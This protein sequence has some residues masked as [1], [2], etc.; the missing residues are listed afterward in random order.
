MSVYGQGLDVAIVAGAD[1]SAQQ[2]KP[3]NQGGTLAGSADNLFGILQG[4]PQAAEHATVRVTG[5][6]KLYMSCSLGAGADIMVS[7]ATSGVIALATSGYCSFGKVFI[8]AASGSIG[9]AFLFGGPV[10]R[11]LA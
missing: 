9:T 3:V 5:F 1:L 10:R 4:K 7:N 2:Y 8:A 11:L 6:T